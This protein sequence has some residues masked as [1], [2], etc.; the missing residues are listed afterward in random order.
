MPRRQRSPGAFQVRGGRWFRP[1]RPRL[2]ARS[3]SPS[4]TEGEENDIESV[5]YETCNED[6]K[7]DTT[8]A[9]VA[10]AQPVTEMLAGTDAGAAKIVEALCD[11]L[12][13]KDEES[14]KFKRGMRKAKSKAE[15]RKDQLLRLHDVQGQC[16][17][18]WWCIRQLKANAKT[19]RHGTQCP[20]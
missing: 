12:K 20:P 9:L 1:P 6:T 14:E 3:R 7:E 18:Y 13:K 11:R 15:K 17:R 5:G 19:A 10:S 8:A 16:S 2:I 4:C